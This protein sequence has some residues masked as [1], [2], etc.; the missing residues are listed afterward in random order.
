MTAVSPK[1]LE[2]LEKR[3]AA[4][5]I[6]KDDLL[7]KFILSSGKGGQKMNKT[8]SCVYLKHLPSGIEVKWGKERSRELNRFFAR[9]K[10][11]ELLEKEELGTKTPQELKQE[12]LRKQKKRRK[13]RQNI[14]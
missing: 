3:M 14:L 8:A 7:E 4:L 1:K 12:K 2:E 5:H 13:R 10:L 6:T 9:R 11:C